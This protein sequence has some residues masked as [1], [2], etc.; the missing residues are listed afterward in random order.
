M[1]IAA[2]L[3]IIL[4]AVALV[5][6][7]ANQFAMTTPNGAVTACPAP[8][9]TSNILCSVTDGYYVSVAGAAY[10]KINVGAQTGGVSS[11]NGRT[12]NV[13]PAANDYKYSDLAGKPTQISCSTS[14]QGNTGFV[15]SGCTI[16]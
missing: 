9:S 13:L 2:F 5:A 4:I 10:A 15:A 3:I 7:S 16:Q 8:V 11:Y 1:K 6:Q 12:G 14:T